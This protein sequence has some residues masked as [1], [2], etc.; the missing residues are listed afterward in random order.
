M[1]TATAALTS[2]PL[3]QLIDGLQRDLEMG[4]GVVQIRL[5]VTSALTVRILG[6]A[7]DHEGAMLI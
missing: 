6:D 7:I 4:D 2:G 1:V 3:A 5:S